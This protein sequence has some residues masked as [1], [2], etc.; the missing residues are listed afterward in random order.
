MSFFSTRH[1]TPI[2]LVLRSRHVLSVRLH[3]LISR[4]SGTTS[5]PQLR[6]ETPLRSNLLCQSCPPLFFVTAHAPQCHRRRNNPCMV[7]SIR[8]SVRGAFLMRS[9]DTVCCGAV[10]WSKFLKY[11][12]H[13]NK[14]MSGYGTHWSWFAERVCAE[15][16]F[17]TVA[18]FFCSLVI[19][20]RF[21]CR[22]FVV[23][24]AGEEV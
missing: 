12:P 24:S 20:R 15:F 3:L 16:F 21:W 18:L 4:A 1:K 22:R 5:R 10:C 8:R 23:E 19:S 7:V 9:R 2:D 11:Q 17:V 14:C 6:V 13:S